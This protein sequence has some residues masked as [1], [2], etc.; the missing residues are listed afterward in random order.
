MYRVLGFGGL[1]FQDFGGLGSMGFLQ[2]Q[3]LKPYRQQSPANE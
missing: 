2:K 1:G 3:L